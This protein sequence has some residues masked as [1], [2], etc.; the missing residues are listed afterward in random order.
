MDSDSRQS[1]GGKTTDQVF[2]EQ[3]EALLAISGVAAVALGKHK[4]NPC[5]LVFVNSRE[6]RIRETI[7]RF[8][9]GIPVKIRYSGSIKAV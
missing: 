3:R 1:T 7:P 9:D 8:L 4:G 6:P 2:K 5:I